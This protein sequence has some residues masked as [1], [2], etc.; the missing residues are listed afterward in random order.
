MGMFQSVETSS[1][2]KHYLTSFSFIGFIDSSRLGLNEPA[3]TDEK[4]K[5]VDGFL[6]REEARHQYLFVQKRLPTPCIYR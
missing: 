4:V 2:K 1:S 5:P 6:F 3:A